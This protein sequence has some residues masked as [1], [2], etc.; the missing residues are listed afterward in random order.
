MNKVELFLFIVIVALHPHTYYVRLFI[1]FF[2]DISIIIGLE[3][4]VTGTVIWAQVT[5]FCTLF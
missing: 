1:L 3:S 4:A 2:M 5:D